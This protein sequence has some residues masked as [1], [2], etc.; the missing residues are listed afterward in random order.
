MLSLWLEE[1]ELGG[2]VTEASLW[3][4]FARFWF[5]AIFDLERLLFSNFGWDKKRER[6]TFWCFF[7]DYWKVSSVVLH[8]EH[9]ASYRTSPVWAWLLFLSHRVS[10]FG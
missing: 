2:E 6:E 9:N 5:D 3:S 7:F 8:L 1:V 10:F 4:S